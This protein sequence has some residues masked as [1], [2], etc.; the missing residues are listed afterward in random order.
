MFFNYLRDVIYDPAHAELDLQQLP[1]DFRELGEGLQY[2]AES[3]LETRDLAKALSR[4]DLNGKLPAPDNEMAAPLKSL[5]SSLRHLTWQS[6]QVAKGDYKQRVNFMGEFAEAFNSMIEQLGQQRQALLQEIESGKQKTQDLEQ[7]NN[8]FEVITAQASQWVAVIEKG[9]GEVLFCNYPVRNI[10]LEDEF[11]AQLCAQL[12]QQM[13]TI[14]DGA[15]SYIVGMSLSNGDSSQYFSVLVHSL[16][17]RGISAVAFSLTDISAEKAHINELE[18]VAYRDMLTKVYNRHYGMQRLDQWLEEKAHFVLCFIDIDNLKYV[19]DKFGHGKGDKYILDV[20]EVLGT[21]A[22]DTLVCRLGGDE[23]M[24]LTQGWTQEA[25][26]S[27]L[28]SLRDQLVALNNLPDASY[29]H[30]MSYGVIEVDEHNETAR[31]DLLSIAD[32]KMYV[33]KREHKAQRTN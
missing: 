22:P 16:R 12:M 25:T 10:L 26:E 20:A 23:F 1:E 18:D 4:G 5:H 21:F 30:S 27:R 31:A 2:F 8:L 7:N 32:D 11:E 19:N 13:N 17:W 14:D 24:L 6:Q 3:V 29:N 15:P 28:E 9:T 33:Y